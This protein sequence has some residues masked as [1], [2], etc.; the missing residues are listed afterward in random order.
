MVISLYFNRVKSFMYEN[1]NNIKAES[2]FFYIVEHEYPNTPKVTHIM[3]QNI[4]ICVKI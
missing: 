4:D 2:A 1:R 3:I